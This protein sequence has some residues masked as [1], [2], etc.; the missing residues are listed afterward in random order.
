MGLGVMQ[1]CSALPKC[2]HSAFSRGCQ[3][4]PHSITS[5]SPPGTAGAGCSTPHTGEQGRGE[6]DPSASC[7]GTDHPLCSPAGSLL[8]HVAFAPSPNTAGGASAHPGFSPGGWCVGRALR[9][10]AEEHL[11]C[12]GQGLFQ[13]QAR[14]QQ[15]EMPEELCQEAGHGLGRAGLGMPSPDPR[16]W[17]RLRREQGGGGKG[18]LLRSWCQADQ[19]RMEKGNTGTAF[20]AVLGMDPPPR[21]DKGWWM[22]V[23]WQEGSGWGMLAATSAGCPCTGHPRT[24]ASL[25]GQGCLPSLRLSLHHTRCPSPA[26]RQGEALEAAG[27]WGAARVCPRLCPPQQLNT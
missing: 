24:S 3:E 16:Q 6:M 21:G 8:W 18:L 14:H 27:P 26:A 22:G 4:H 12:P 19:P 20:P 11:P 13:H 5:Q 10:A 1:A 15:E 2:Q 25:L 17:V 23:M 9:G 7:E